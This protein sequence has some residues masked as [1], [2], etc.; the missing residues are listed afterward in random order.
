[1]KLEVGKRV[2]IIGDS[3]DYTSD[4]HG[5]IGTILEIG[6][7]DCYVEVDGQGIWWIWNYNMV[8]PDVEI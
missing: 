8:E 2:K 3:S 4:L 7:E 1:M 5:C 6:Y